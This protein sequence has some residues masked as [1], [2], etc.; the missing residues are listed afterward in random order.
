MSSDN[1]FYVITMRL[2]NV[3]ETWGWKFDIY[4]LLLSELYRNPR[5]VR[6]IKVYQDTATVVLGVIT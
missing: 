5:F 6:D 3:K 4:L 1:C 2:G